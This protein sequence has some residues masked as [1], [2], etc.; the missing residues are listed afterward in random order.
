MT[1]DGEDSLLRSDAAQRFVYLEDWR[2]LRE[3]LDGESLRTVCVLLDEW[4]NPELGA[5]LVAHLRR[6]SPG[7]AGGRAVTLA[8]A[9]MTEDGMQADERGVPGS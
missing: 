9:G 8:L 4:R 1:S 2:Y 7:I 3:R 5:K 6:L